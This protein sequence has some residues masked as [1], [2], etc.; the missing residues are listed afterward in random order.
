MVRPVKIYEAAKYLLTT[1]IYQE[2]GATLSLDW[3]EKA[4]VKSQDLESSLLQCQDMSQNEQLKCDRMETMVI[5]YGSEALKIAPGQGK[6]P[7]SL[8]MDK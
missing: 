6:R 4:V 7:M 8:L 3:L 2:E 5:Q 1:P